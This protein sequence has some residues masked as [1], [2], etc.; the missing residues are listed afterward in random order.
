MRTDN[1]AVVCVAVVLI[2]LASASGQ[3][4][5]VL[6]DNSAGPPVARIEASLTQGIAPLSVMFDALKSVPAKGQIVRYDWDFNDE[7][8]HNRRFEHGWLAAHRFERP[9]SYTVTLSVHDTAGGSAVTTVTLTVLPATGPVYY[10]SFSEGDDGRSPEQARNPKTPWR[11]G[12]KLKAELQKVEP[13]TRL[14]LKRGD[15]FSAA[16]LEFSRREGLD[17]STP[18]VVGAYGDGAK[19]ILR[20]ESSALF[21]PATDGL[22]LED[23]HCDGGGK[24]DRAVFTRGGGPTTVNHLVLRRL[25][26]E[27]FIIGVFPSGGGREPNR[28]IFMEE[29]LV[30]DN[31][32]W[33]W[34]GGDGHHMVIRHCE[35]DNNGTSAKY[36]HNLYFDADVFLIEDNNI[37]H[38]SGLG[39]NTHHTRDTIIR[40]NRIHHNG[41]SPGG[42]IGISG[43][44]TKDTP[45]QYVLE[46]IV[47]EG[48]NIYDNLLGCWLKGVKDLTFRNNV[49]CEQ[50]SRIF[51]GMNEWMQDTQV[52]HNTFYGNRSDI[53]DGS[54]AN[55]KVMNN[56]FFRNDG[57]VYNGAA[58]RSNNLYG[59]KV[60]EGDEPGA[61]CGDPRFV[62]AVNGEFH[63]RADS[64]AVDHG[65]K[66]PV[67]F[68]FSGKARP[69]GKAPDI[70]PFESG[71]AAPPIARQ[72]VDIGTGW[73][74]FSPTAYD[75]SEYPLKHLKQ[76]A[77]RIFYLS[78]KGND[79]TAEIYFWDG[80]RLV[81]S[82]GSPTGETGVAYGSDP[83]NPT[84]PIR[85]YKNWS[86]V[87]P[88]RHG[89]TVDPR[90]GQARLRYEFPDWCLFKRGD[91]FDMEVTGDNLAVLGGRS[92]TAMQIVGAYGGL[93]AARPRFINSERN[94]INRWRDP[95][96]K[97]MAYVSLHFDGRGKRRGGGISFM[98]QTPAAVNILL[99][100]CWF[101]GVRG[102]NM[103]KTSAQITL[104]RCVVTDSWQ[105]TGDHLQGLFFS[106]T[107]DM[108]LRIEECVFMRNGFARGDPATSWPPTGRQK[109]DVFNR[110]FYLS[111]ECNS[112]A[113]GV[114]DTI[115]MIGSSGDQFRCGMRVERNFF[116]QGYIG[117]GGHGGY[118][119]SDGPT[120]TFV[121]NV[122]QRFRSS[123][124]ID[125]RGH[126][127]WGV[128]LT[129]GAYKVEVARN[130]VTCAQHPA[131]GSAFKLSPLGWYN[132]CHTFHYPSRDNDIHDNVFD[133]GGARAAIDVVDG[134]QPEL[135][136]GSNWKYPGVTKNTVRDNVLINAAGVEWEYAP[137]GPAVG[138]Q[139]DTVFEGNKV[140]AS[141]TKAAAALGW[142][143]P[144]RTLK[145]Y[146]QSLGHE[147]TSSDGF[148]EFFK[149]AKQQRKG[150]W[151]EEY[152]ARALVNY[153]REGL[154]MKAL[155]A[156]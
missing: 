116:Y 127:A 103:Q 122:L 44:V 102:N 113:S 112:M 108:Q 52:Y 9:G 142:P 5:T 131:A 15:T 59:D 144:D 79:S 74:E 109:W 114:F 98:Y 33:G 27:G 152:T 48:N 128:N 119:D 22:V 132:Y 68:D 28:F 30:R 78:S 120:G 75:T 11:S 145:T 14:L 115:S 155:P 58:E 32:K 87:A 150:N 34:L 51:G 101:D 53:F 20:C 111:G 38:S 40:R 13:G 43:F 130:I 91:T 133:A 86:Y 151:R 105:D 67:S 2:S 143:D 138:T 25:T 93:A 23:L 73:T 94:F 99:E 125:N 50:R 24:G 95:V 46:H 137:Q 100:D 60:P 149:E 80:K 49:F 69:I 42:G 129:S 156:E 134:V 104:R 62:D 139:N 21:R 106:G 36:D 123:G 90:D 141:R 41:R 121:D 45:P 96:P 12:E 153:M 97:H 110:N 10:F 39:V 7:S 61:V 6:A 66:T 37:H 16:S 140:Y 148:I 118:P 83:F 64:P 84:G 88:S 82:S 70:G 135:L 81:D 72:A 85:T 154:G 63:L 136:A 146:M 65:A 29:C 124:A 92:K 76:P 117:L 71:D 57:V 35:F 1:I 55:L 4:E 89:A 54:G 18:I 147:V 31:R 8:P 26:I 56:I 19:P 126:P 107:R 47:V 3:N 77:S 17:G